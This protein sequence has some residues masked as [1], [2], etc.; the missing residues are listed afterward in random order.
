MSKKEIHKFVRVIPVIRSFSLL[1]QHT[2]GVGP[3]PEHMRLRAAEAPVWLHNDLGRV[4]KVLHQ[5]SEGLAAKQ[6][7]E[8]EKKDFVVKSRIRLLSAVPQNTGLQKGPFRFA[9]ERSRSRAR[10]APR[11]ATRTTT[12]TR[13]DC[14]ATRATTTC[15]GS[16]WPATGAPSRSSSP[17]TTEGSAGTPSWNATGID[18]GRIVVLW[19]VY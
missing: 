1:A 12:T 4:S 14:R 18:D 6:V 19:V 10:R 2:S 8:I 3:P 7:R 5:E 13:T 15:A 9:G 11:A 17:R 16:A